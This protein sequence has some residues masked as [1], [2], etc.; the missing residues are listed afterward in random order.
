[1]RSLV[2]NLSFHAMLDVSLED[3][4]IGDMNYLD[5]VFTNAREQT[6]EITLFCDSRVEM[7]SLLD[8]LREQITYTLQEADEDA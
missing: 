8:G 5:L 6:F 3:V 7:I 2:E 4:R 1:M